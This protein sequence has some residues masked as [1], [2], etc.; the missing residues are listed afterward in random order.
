MSEECQE[1]VEKNKD[2]KKQEGRG[3][4]GTQGKGRRKKEK[5]G[6]EAGGKEKPK[7]GGHERDEKKRRKLKAESVSHESISDTEL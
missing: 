3:A 2:K 4:E 5:K 7:Q 1:D 6:F